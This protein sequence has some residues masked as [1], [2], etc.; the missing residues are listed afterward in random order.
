MTNIAALMISMKIG[1]SRYSTEKINSSHQHML[2]TNFLSKIFSFRS[3]SLSVKNSKLEW[4]TYQTFSSQDLSKQQN[5]TLQKS[6][7]I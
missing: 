6:L 1:F 7:E 2:T 3:G 5:N 4:R